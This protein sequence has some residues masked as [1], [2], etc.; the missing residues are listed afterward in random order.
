MSDFHLIYR[1]LFRKKLRACLMM[2]VI[3]IAFLIF[4]V[5]VGFIDVIDSATNVSV[6]NER[7]MTV[8][9][10]NFT[11]P[12]PLAY[13]NKIR[14]ID[15]VS[16]ASY[17]SWYGGYFRDP[18]DIIPTFAVEPES[19]LAVGLDQFFVPPDQKQAWFHDRMG[20]LVGKD[21]ADKYG[22]KLGDQVPL[23]SNIYQRSDGSHVWSFVV[24]AIYTAGKGASQSGILMNY[25]Y[26]NEART[27]AKDNVNFVVFLAKDPSLNDAILHKVDETFANSSAPTRSM[28][29]SAFTKSFLAQQGNITLIIS[30]VVTAAFASILLVV[31]NTMA[32]AIRERTREIAV[33]KTIGFP[34]IRIF[35]LVLSETILL[36][37]A[38]GV[39][40]LAAAQL[41]LS[42]LSKMAAG[43]LPVG[44]GIT[45]HVAGEALA[46]MLALGLLTGLIPALNAMRLN[47]VTGLG[48][49]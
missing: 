40:G 30:S 24:R 29:S 22:W 45:P 7:L 36:S 46:I 6:E 27:F 14:A 41:V 48:R 16:T 47:V 37:V 13:V 32:M 49:I 10:V 35:R 11:Q 44:M 3:F 19:Y 1:N 15:G 8:N 17:A 39:L 20:L 9:K 21:T 43:N 31:G 18:K 26:F 38:G 23:T 42:L 2:V 4:G 28:T 12:L 5:L 25:E 33:M 34:G